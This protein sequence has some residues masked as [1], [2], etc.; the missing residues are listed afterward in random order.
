MRKA[1]LRGSPENLQLEKASY[2]ASPRYPAA[3]AMRETA[4]KDEGVFPFFLS[5][6]KPTDQGEE[7]VVLLV[8]FVVVVVVVVGGFGGTVLRSPMYTQK[9]CIQRKLFLKMG[10]SREYFSSKRVHS[11]KTFL[12]KGCIQRKVF[13]KKGASRQNFSSK[14]VY[15]DKTFPQNGCIQTKHFFKMG[16]SRQNFGFSFDVRQSKV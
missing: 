5:A 10:V 9:G 14:G 12:Q 15:P 2:L 6:A 1:T 4:P 7:G 13:L 11:E 16:A 3:P 8:G